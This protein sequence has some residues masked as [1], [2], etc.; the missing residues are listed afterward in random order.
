MTREIV[1]DTETT[2]LDPKGGHRIIEIA[3]LEIIDYLPTGSVFHT[4]IDPERHVDPDAVRVHGISSEFL[5]GK[6]RFADPE[7][8]DRFVTFVGDSKLVAH[9]A[10]FDRAFVN[11]E[12]ERAGRP[13]LGEERWID[14]LALA[15]R[16]FPG[17]YNSLDALCRRFR[18][19]LAERVRHG[20]RVDAELLAQVYL[21]LR[22]GR[23]QSLELLVVAGQSALQNVTR[24]SYGARPRPLPSR[25]T[26]I[27]IAAHQAFVAQRL[28]PSPVWLRPA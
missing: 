5:Q 21:E 20:A 9:N 16:R 3:C 22:G 19:S 17:M 6:P 8:V 27:E 18:L 14:T 15:Q 13:A 23:E 10:A 2:G 7:V 4:Y 28:G 12:L 26:D 1:L 24:S 25:L 11:D